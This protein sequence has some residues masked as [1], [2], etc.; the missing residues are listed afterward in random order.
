MNALVLW[1][2]FF[3]LET[4]WFRVPNVMHNSEREVLKGYG[5][6]THD[7]SMPKAAEIAK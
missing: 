7:F 3:P 2:E 1:T 4:V 5:A 6:D